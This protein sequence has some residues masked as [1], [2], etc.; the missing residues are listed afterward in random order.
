MAQLPD[1]NDSSFPED[2]LASAVP[3]LVDFAAVWCAPCRTIA[4]HLTALAAQYAGRVKVVQCDADENQATAARYDV[5]ALPTLLLFSR[6]QVVGQIVGAVPR[7]RIE[8]LIERAL[9]SVAA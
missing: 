4:P 2:V 6:G 1:V 8:S 3:V 7:A 5:R 9:T